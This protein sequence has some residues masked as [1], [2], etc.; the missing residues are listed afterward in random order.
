MLAPRGGTQGKREGDGGTYDT[1]DSDEHDERRRER[2]PLDVA[3]C[4]TFK[5]FE[6]I[7]SPRG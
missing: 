7:V 3:L 2:E 6:S 5:E 4:I 1:Q